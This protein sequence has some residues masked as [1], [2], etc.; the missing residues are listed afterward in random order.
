MGVSSEIF[1]G[2]SKPVE[3]FFDIWTPVFFVKFVPE[4]GPSVRILQIFTGRRKMELPFFIKGIQPIQ[5]FSLE[6]IPEDPDRDEKSIFCFPQLMIRSD[7]AAGYD[8]VHVYMVIQLLVPGM[9][10]LNDPG[11]CAEPLF[12]SGEF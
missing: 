8:A 10:D 9:K 4:S 12:I 2:I 7:P 5:V 6:F 11:R 1:N 3:S